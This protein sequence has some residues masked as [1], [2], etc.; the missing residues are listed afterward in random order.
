MIEYEVRGLYAGQWEA[1]FTAS[2]KD[3]ADQILAD[4]RANE[5]GTAFTIKAVRA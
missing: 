3:E 5:S 1:V 2:T 4:Y